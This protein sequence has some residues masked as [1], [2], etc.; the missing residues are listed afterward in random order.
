MANSYEEGRLINW[1]TDGGCDQLL[2]AILPA[3][4]VEHAKVQPIGGLQTAINSLESQFL[5]EAGMNKPDA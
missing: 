4:S 5:A 2:R 1:R 3:Q